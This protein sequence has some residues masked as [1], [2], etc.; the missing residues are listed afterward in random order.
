LLTANGTGN[1]ILMT[2]A[3]SLLLQ[4]E[5]AQRGYIN[6]DPKMLFQNAVTASFE[7]DGVQ[8]ADIAAADYLAQA[9]PE[10]NYDLATD[11]I[12]LI[13]SQKWYVLNGIDILSVYNDYRRTGFPNV[14]LSI[15][16]GSK[17]KVPIRLLYPQREI[18]LNGA[19]VFQ[20]G[21]IDPFSTPVFWNK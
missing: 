2:A 18:N 21:S 3:Q 15:A 4:A 12:K 1:T 17:G 9:N 7:F 19:N 14:P 10:V 13:I 11:K 5:A 16:S 6:D 8:D 20:Q